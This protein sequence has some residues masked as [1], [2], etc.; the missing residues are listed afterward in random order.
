MIT[1]NWMMKITLLYVLLSLAP[2]AV[3]AQGL[4]GPV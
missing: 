2:I 4:S 1:N 3:Q